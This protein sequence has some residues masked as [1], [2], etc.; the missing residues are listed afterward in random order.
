[1]SGPNPEFIEIFVR[2]TSRLVA[3][4][5]NE[6]TFLRKMEVAKIAALQDE[7]TV[8][9]NAYEEGIRRIAADPNIF[10]A[11]EP[12]LKAELHGVVAHFND[13]VAENGRAL[14]AV[15]HSHQRLIKAM[16]DAATESRTRHT[17]YSKTGG[18]PRLT[19][20]GRTAHLSL[21]LDRHL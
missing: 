15:R 16:V 12:A 13:V 4:M 6:I 2:T 20:A 8:L 10:N 21:T 3:V 11:M 18:S 1:M 9:V 7:K 17:G 5:E 19:G 14:E